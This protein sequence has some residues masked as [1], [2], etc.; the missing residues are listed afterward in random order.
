VRGRLAAGIL[1]AAIGIAA[2]AGWLPPLADYTY[3][4]VWWGVLLIVDAWNRRR[5]GCS[6]WAGRATHFLLITVPVSVLFWL[7]YEVLNL[8]SPEWRYRGVQIS[9]AG[10]TLFGFI[11]FATVIPIMVEA[12]WLA[13]GEISMPKAVL[14][15]VRQRRFGLVCV[16]AALLAVPLFNDIFWLN[17]GIWIAPALLILP[18]TPMRESASAGRFA[19]GIVWAGLGAGFF[20]ELINWPAR[21]HW[22]YLILPR[23][24]HLFQMPLAGY[25]GFIPFGLTAV[26]VYEWQLRLRARRATGA[27]LYA[28]AL[29]ALYI[30]TAVYERRG[31]WAS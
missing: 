22:E 17:Q 11:S 1:I 24:P 14:E 26:I 15:K 9:I 5:I 31:L 30:L 8:M 10:Q 19:A 27:V 23:A 2:T 6:L 25:I 20:W 21:T 12:Y 18:F 29:A 4:I 28:A 3:P 7:V 13:L 16:G